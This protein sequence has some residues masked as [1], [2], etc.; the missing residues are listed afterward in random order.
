[1]GV[2]KRNNCL[3]ARGAVLGLVLHVHRI[4]TLLLV[5]LLR[6]GLAVDSGGLPCIQDAHVALHERWLRLFL[7]WRFAIIPR[8]FPIG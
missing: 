1:M 7:Y 3:V 4:G 8:W 2:G 6:H 5:V